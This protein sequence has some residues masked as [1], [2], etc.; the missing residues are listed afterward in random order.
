MMEARFSSI[1]MSA[2][3]KALMDIIFWSGD[4]RYL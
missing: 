2:I 4:I 1:G 3:Y